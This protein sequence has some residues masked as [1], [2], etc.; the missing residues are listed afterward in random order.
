MNRPTTCA[1][2]TKAIRAALP[3]GDT[4]RLAR[5]M[6]GVVVGQMLP[7]GVIKGGSSLLL[8]YGGRNVRYTRDVDTARTLPL[9]AYVAALER[10]LAAGWNGFTGKL[11]PVVPP[12]PAGVPPAYVMIPFDIKL[13]YN[14]RPWQTVRIEVGHDEIGDADRAEAVLPEELAVLFE[15]LGFPRPRPLP[16]MTLAHQVAQ[17]LHALSSPGSDRAHDLVDL[18]LIARLATLDFAEVRSTCIRLFAYRRAQSWPPALSKG[19]GWDDL[20]AAAKEGLPVEPDADRAIVWTQDFI[21]RIEE[22]GKRAARAV[23][24]DE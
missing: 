21:R 4:V 17:K 20:Y 11:V 3:G 2:L 23:T 5:A 9:D 10:A 8:R 22:A 6:G 15:K 16:V 19:R 13:A 24:S 1:N 7:D 12:S 18:Q 14:R